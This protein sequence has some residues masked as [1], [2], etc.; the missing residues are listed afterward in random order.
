[1]RQGRD[2]LVFGDPLERR[3]PD[4]DPALDQEPRSGWGWGEAPSSGGDDDIDRFLREK[5]PH[6]G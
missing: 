1:M 4:E 6:H 5:P 3:G 2:E